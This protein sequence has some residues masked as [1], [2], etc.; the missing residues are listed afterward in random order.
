[1][2]RPEFFRV[3]TIEFIC[4]CLVSAPLFAATPSDANVLK[5]TY[6]ALESQL[7]SSPLHRPARI[8][9][10]ES[11]ETL[12]GDLHALLDHPIDALSAA[13]TNPTRWC[14]VF[15]L[16]S[17]TKLCQANGRDSPTTL[18]VMASSSKSQGTAGATNS[19]FTLS[20]Q[21]N[22]SEYLKVALLAD[23]GP[24]GTSQLMLQLEAIALTPTRTFLHLR[25]TYNT[26]W[27]GRMA[28]QT[29]LQ[30]LG[31]GKVGFTRVEPADS[32]ASLIGGAR[33]V[34]ER[35]TMRYFLG[36]E[37]SLARTS[38]ESAARFQ[39]MASC[40]YDAV[41]KYPVQL[42]E[43]GRSEYLGMKAAEYKASKVEPK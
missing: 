23:S 1:M 34:I 15:L 12:S 26:N 8:G 37:C 4:L 30:T 3:F 42:H 17:N 33:G 22:D 19:T 20:V 41:E 28:M 2:N 31:R 18:T 38:P 9:S 16:L 32:P 43:M 21:K 5:S 25:Y 29:Y 39:A 10:T 13:T 24:M 27:M 14:E 40:W 36:L 35:N 7:Q 6:A 11:A